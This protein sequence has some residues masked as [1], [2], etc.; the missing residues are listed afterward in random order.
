MAGLWSIERTELCLQ[1][2]SDGLSASQIAERMGGIS[3]N[4][5]I[6]KVHRAGLA[7]TKPRSTRHATVRARRR[8]VEPS[9]LAVV[10]KVSG[11]A[12]KRG[13]APGTRFKPDVKLPSSP[14]V[15]AAPLPPEPPKPDKLFKLS[16]LEDN[17]CRFPFGD[18]KSK[19][20]GF[21]GCVKAAG[22]SYCP[23]HA[24]LTTNSVQ[25]AGR[26]RAPVRVIRR[27]FNDDRAMEV[28][29]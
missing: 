15:N 6:G 7:H 12:T 19:D 11:K 1:L 14:A 21:C 28:A 23:G 16:D 10:V 3:R 27:R 8:G 20:F 24:H 13:I 26:S 2:W 18:P 22:S 4:A 9:H 17:Q 29:L 25:P 5:V